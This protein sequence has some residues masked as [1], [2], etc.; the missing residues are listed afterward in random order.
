MLP[1]RVI[2]GEPGLACGRLISVTRVAGEPGDHGTLI[3]AAIESTTVRQ[4][5]VSV[6]IRQEPEHT[7]DQKPQGCFIFRGRATLPPG[8]CLLWASRARKVSGEGSPVGVCA[9]L[10]EWT[11]GF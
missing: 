11:R 9:L 6:S 8:Q 7:R 10:D 5:A 2:T 1:R 3:V 4:L